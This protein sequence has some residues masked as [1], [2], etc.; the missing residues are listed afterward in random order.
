MQA[1]ALAKPTLSLEQLAAKFGRS[2]ERYK[3]LLRR[4]YLS[5]GTVTAVIE[6]RQPERLTNRFLQ[7]LDGL[8]ASW[9][10]QEQ[11]LLHQSATTYSGSRHANAAL[12]KRAP[13]L[14]S[15]IACGLS[16]GSWCPYAGQRTA[17]NCRSSHHSPDI[18]SMNHRYL[19]GGDAGSAPLTT[20]PAFPFFCEFTGKLRFSE[21]PF[22]RLRSE[23]WQIPAISWSEFPTQRTGDVN[24]PN[25]ESRPTERS[26]LHRL[27]GMLQTPATNFGVRST[28][29]PGGRPR[30]PHGH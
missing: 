1:L 25:S 6:G 12:E 26:M 29:R 23:F 19:V 20:P 16:L 27:A 24:P 22:S 21:H 2:T 7:N 3:R 9:S 8:P 14:A 4:S 10:E 17:Q 30:H 15:M 28:N 13:D 18:I 11:L 5:L